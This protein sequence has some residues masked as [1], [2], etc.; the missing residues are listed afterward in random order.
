VKLGHADTA[1]IVAESGTKAAMGT[2]YFWLSK[3]CFDFFPA[4]TLRNQRGYKGTLSA[5][6]SLKYM[7]LGGATDNEC[8]VTFEAENNLDF[9]LGTGYLRNTKL[10]SEGD[11]ACISR[12]G[13]AEYELRILRQ[14][15]VAYNN[16]LPYATT[17]IGARGKVYGF[18]ENALFEQ[19]TGT[20]VG[21]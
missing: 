18:V 19:L 9:R 10:A 14:G 12:I 20:R 7:D 15:S 13:E 3:D 11:L 17:F 2:Q 21:Q 4:L 16:A 6:I 8:R 5:L 1:R